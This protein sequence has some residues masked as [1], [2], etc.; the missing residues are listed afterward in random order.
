MVKI[1]SHT[2]NKQDYWAAFK[3]MDFDVSK[4]VADAVSH[5][6]CLQLMN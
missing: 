5:A 2:E 1:A 3:Q 4:N 6:C